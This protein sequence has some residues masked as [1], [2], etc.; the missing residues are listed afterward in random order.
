MGGNK[1]KRANKQLALPT[2]ICKSLWCWIHG[3]VNCLGCILLMQLKLSFWDYQGKPALHR[4]SNT[5]PQPPARE[6]SPAPFLRLSFLSPR[7]AHPNPDHHPPLL[8]FSVRVARHGTE[9]KRMRKAAARGVW[10]GR[11]DFHLLPSAHVS[12]EPWSPRFR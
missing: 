7:G 6:R 3:V 4:G 8:A 1:D 2:K 11:Q 9:E 10:A 5:T 12:T